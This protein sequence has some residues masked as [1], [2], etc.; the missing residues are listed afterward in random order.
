MTQKEKVE[1]CSQAFIAWI[2]QE[3]KNKDMTVCDKDIEDM[4]TSQVL[5]KKF[6]AFDINIVLPEM[7]L[8]ILGICVDGNPGQV[9]IVLK[10]LLNSIKERTGKP[11]PQGYVITTWDFSLHFP[12]K[13][14][15]MD[16]PEMYNKYKD[17]WD[18]QKIE[19]THPAMSDN[20]CDTPEWW[21]EVME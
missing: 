3:Q 1:I 20:L 5:L 4:F 14:P 7:L 11:I 15:I 16:F 21:K 8:L 18:A 10:D 19:R 6:K 2:T 12:G 9:Q 17:L 13:F